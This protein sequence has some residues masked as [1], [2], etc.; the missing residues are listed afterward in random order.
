MNVI[1]DHIKTEHKDK[2]NE[3]WTKSLENNPITKSKEN[4]ASALNI[5]NRPKDM[6]TNKEAKFD[7]KN[8]ESDEIEIIENKEQRNEVRE[9]KDN[10]FC[11]FCQHHLKR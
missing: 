4:F 1:Q 8:E 3:I 5:E 2:V 10:Q 9:T 7:S 11:E 6:E